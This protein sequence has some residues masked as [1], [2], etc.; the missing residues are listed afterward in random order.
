MGVTGAMAALALPGVAGD[1]TKRC[2]VCRLYGAAAHVQ[3]CKPGLVELQG[4]GLCKA[5]CAASA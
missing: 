5:T 4:C 3:G 1:A 2:P